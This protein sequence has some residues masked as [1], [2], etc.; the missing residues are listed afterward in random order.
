VFCVRSELD[1]GP[2]ELGIVLESARAAGI[3][4]W[5]AKECASKGGPLLGVHLRQA[6]RT[7][8]ENEW[9]VSFELTAFIDDSWGGSLVVRRERGSWSLL[10]LEYDD[11][12]ILR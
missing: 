8:G 9:W 10:K 7:V 2:G 12:R 3:Q 1:L 11:W 5:P 6:R 4:A